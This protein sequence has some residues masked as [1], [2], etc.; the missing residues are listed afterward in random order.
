MAQPQAYNRETD[1]TE[2]DGDDTNHAGINAELDAAALSINQLRDN[3]ALI[4]RDD[5]AL[6]NGIVTAESLSDSAFNAVLGEV[7]TATAAASASADRS[8]LFATQAEADR[9][10]AQ[11]A[12]AAAQSS[13]TA[14]AGSATAAASSQTAAANSATSAATSASTATTKANEASSSATNAANSAT[15][16]AGSAT[17]ASTQATNAANSATAAATSAT[18][19]ANSATT[20][21]TQAGIATTQASNAAAS[22]TAAATSFDDFEDRYLGPKSAAPTTDNDGNP[23]LT[24]AMYF[25]TSISEMRVYTGT[26]W[27]AVGS[28]ING[29]T[30]RATYTATAGQTTFSVVY[31]VG[32]VDVYLNGLKLQAV[33]E[34]T[35]T[36]GTSIVLAS[37]A[38]AGDIVDIVAYGVFSVAD[39]N[40]GQ[41]AA[42]DGAGGSLF[43]T[44]AGFI[45]RLM[46]SAGSALVGFIQAGTGAIQRTMQDKNRESVSVTDFTGADPTG[47]ADSTTAIRNAMTRAV[48]ANAPLNVNG[49]FRYTEQINVPAKLRMIGAGITSYED[50]ASRSRSC[51][52]KDFNGL[53]FLFNADDCFV[54]GIQFD[55]VDGRTGDN[56]QVTGSR[57]CAPAIAVTNAGQDGLRI[58]QTGSTGTG[59]SVQNANLW[60]IGRI[61]ALSN[62][63]YGIN[64]DDT[65]TGGSGNWPLGLPDCNAGFIGLAETDRNGSDGLRFGNTIDNHVSHVVAQTNTGYGVRFDPYARNNTISKCYTEANTAGDGIITANATQNIVFSSSRAVTLDNGW[66]NSGGN[67]NLLLKH[68]S[69]IGQDGAFN[70]CPWLWGSEFYTVNQATNGQVFIGGYVD[71]NL[72]AWLRI[73]KGT[74]TGTKMTLVTKRNGNTP[75]DRLSIDASGLAV[76]QNTAG[77]GIGKGVNDTTTAGIFLGDSGSGTNTRINMVGSGTS[78]DTKIAFYNGNGYTGGIVTDGTT[79]SYGTSSDYRL[80]VNVQPLDGAAALAA[81]MSWPIDTFTWLSSG[82]A[83]VGVIAHKLQAV[84]PTSVTGEKDAVEIRPVVDADGNVIGHVEQLKPQS[85]DYSTL[86]PELVAAVQYL[87]TRLQAI[88]ARSQSTPDQ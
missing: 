50:V 59:Y 68:V 72:P 31:D 11:A 13:Q 12:A 39:L 74:G 25:D 28:A 14:A 24:G 8:T 29:T 21:A 4:Q 37:G 53:G 64:I 40:A 87:A 61:A 26:V 62:G 23:L 60:Y 45:T 22:A 76:L 75:V 27:K 6:K 33:A 56:V 69:G 5:G 34:F 2:R 44:V 18:N 57:F 73:E 80:K 19:S 1:F 32:F 35:A 51:F 20:A 77:F 63:R 43:T 49:R 66:T 42:T 36:N 70:S 46:S 15:A 65:N 17:T 52:I 88:E 55:S 30:N 81:V 48:A 86:V 3:L 58:G 54:D 85:V 71:A 16:A 47:V 79:T 38:T 78:Y 9:I 10:A 82:L 7:A 41:I 83:D 67:S 84:K